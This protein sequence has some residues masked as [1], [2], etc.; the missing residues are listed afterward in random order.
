ML[1]NKLRKFIKIASFNSHEVTEVIVR[2]KGNEDNVGARRVGTAINPYLALINHSCDP[3]HG[4]VWN[5]NKE[6][7]KIGILYT[8]DT[9]LLVHKEIKVK[10]KPGKVKKL[11]L[12]YKNIE[13]NPSIE[14]CSAFMKLATDVIQP[15]HALLVVVEDKLQ[16][17]LLK[18]EIEA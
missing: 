13:T 17:C 18:K 10:T 14:N 3:N 4:R 1:A 2:R 7:K 16:R 6:G 8:I 12:L 9:I 5:S 15:P 11:K